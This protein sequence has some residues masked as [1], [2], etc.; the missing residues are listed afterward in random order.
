MKQTS[1]FI[2]LMMV[3]PLLTQ[4]AF[5]AEK[6]AKFT[7]EEATIH[8]VHSAL[9]EKQISC[10]SLVN[11]YLDRIKKY[12]LSTKENAPLNAF[13]SINPNALA[14][15][16]NL[17]ERYQK[18][19]QLVGPLHCIPTVVKDNID[20]LG[21]DTSAGSLALLGTK[22]QQDAFLVAKLRKAGAI[23]LGKTSMDEFSWGMIGVSSRSGRIGNAYQPNQNPGGS[24]GGT[25]VAIS[26]NFAILGIGTDNSGSIRIPAAFNGVMGLRPSTGLISQTGIFPMGNLDG[27][28]GPITRNVKDL[29]I[30]LDVIARKDPT[31]K[32]TLRA[33][34]PNTYLSYLKEDGLQGKRIGIVRS[35]GNM[36]PFKDM[37]PTNIAILHEAFQRLHRQGASLVAN[38]KLDQ[39][40]NDREDNQ[41]GEIQEVNQYLKNTTSKVKLFT[42]ICKSSQTR[43][44]GDETKCLAFVDSVPGKNSKKYDQVLSTFQQNKQYVEAIMN[45]HE[46]DALLIP[47]ARTGTATYDPKMIN[48]WQAP[49]SSNAGLPAMALIAGFHPKEKMPVGFELVAKQYAEPVL[50]EMAYAYEKKNPKRKLPEM[51]SADEL[52]VSLTPTELN[53]IYTMLGQSAYEMVLK[54]GKPEDLTAAAFKPLV[55][56]TLA[57]AQ[58][59]LSKED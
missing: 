58:T 38:I 1:I 44:F 3:H 14:E 49:V 59:K 32:T 9:K 30:V 41:A 25:A 39:F 48:T 5:S 21:T 42:D 33:S 22:P 23:I 19:N 27:V 11:A 36:D 24:S 17:D 52:S 12:N 7:L 4:T 20:T 54:K 16:K 31:D 6:K 45:E 10:E 8:S 55:K 29:A 40:I 2:L 51:P 50:I 57:Q 46:L 56:N 47:I 53:Q 35:I 43:N 13:T 34:R 26:A 28:A 18:N 37:T 15:A